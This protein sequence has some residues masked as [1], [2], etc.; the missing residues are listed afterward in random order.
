MSAISLNREIAES[1]IEWQLMSSLT[2]ELYSHLHEQIWPASLKLGLTCTLERNIVITIDGKLGMH[3]AVVSVRDGRF[4]MRLHPTNMC[5]NSLI[6]GGLFP[7]C[8]PMD[9]DVVAALRDNVRIFLAV[10]VKCYQNSHCEFRI[11]SRHQC[12]RY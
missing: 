11:Q 2:D 8:W 3:R 1:S 7:K 5:A 4:I 10:V 9:G 12:I 6:V